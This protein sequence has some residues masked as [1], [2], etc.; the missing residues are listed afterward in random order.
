MQGM[1]DIL[2]AGGDQVGG[3]GERHFDLGG[4]P[5]DGICYLST[6]GCPYPSLVGFK[7]GAYIPAILGMWGPGFAVC[8]F[9]LNQYLYPRRGNGGT[10]EI[11]Q[12]IDLGPSR[13]LGVYAGTLEKVEGE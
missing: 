1:Q 3:G 13:E 5:R 12:S 6:L 2:Y 4:E 7:S 9:L 8:R 10:V 11:I